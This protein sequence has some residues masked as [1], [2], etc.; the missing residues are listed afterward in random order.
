[1]FIVRSGAGLGRTVLPIACLSNGEG[2]NV[3]H[4]LTRTGANF[5]GSFMRDCLYLGN[6]PV[7]KGS[8]CG[9]STGVGSRAA[10]HSPHLGRAVLA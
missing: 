10:S 6:G 4:A 7:A 2:R 5:S 1:M 3:D 9:K 8:R